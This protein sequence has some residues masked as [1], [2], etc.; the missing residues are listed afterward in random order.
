M[1]RIVGEENN[2]TNIENI[3]FDEKAVK[4]MENGQIYI[5]REGVVYDALGRTVK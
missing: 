3:Q 5:L 4:F 2:A 1:I